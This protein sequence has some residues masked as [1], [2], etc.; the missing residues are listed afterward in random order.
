MEVPSHRDEEQEL[1]RGHVVAAPRQVG[2]S[3]SPADTPAMAFQS[4][5]SAAR[6]LAGR[7]TAA[8]RARR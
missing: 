3:A 7:C 4:P 2:D 6:R 8:C 5:G 1:R